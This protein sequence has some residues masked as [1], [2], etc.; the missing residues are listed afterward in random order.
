[1]AHARRHIYQALETGQARM[2][3]VLAYIAQLYA[4]EKRARQSSIQGDDLRLLR[5]QGSRPVTEQLHLYL[6]KISE[7]LLPKSDAGQA[8]AYMR[9]AICPSTTSG[10]SVP[11]AALPSDG[12][13]GRFWAVTGAA[14][15]KRFSEASSVIANC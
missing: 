4:V 11:C 8:V 12:T 3:A 1:M 7:Q 6:L 2:G 9:T 15:Q 14:K 13:T 5:E 10:P